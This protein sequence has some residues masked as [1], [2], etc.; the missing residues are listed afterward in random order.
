MP[1]NIRKELFALESPIQKMADRACA[2]KGCVRFDIGDPD[3]PTPPHIIEAAVKALRD[4]KTKYTSQLGIE[5]LREAIAHY[6]KTA[7]QLNHIT[8]DNVLVTV[9]GMGAMF[10]ACSALLK[11]GEKILFPEPSW[12]AGYTLVVSSGPGGFVTT[13]FFDDDNNFILD[14]S[15]FKNHNIKLLLVNSPE[16]PTGRVLNK[17]NLGKLVR[18]AEKYDLTIISDEVYEPMLYDGAKHISIATLAP[19]RTIKVNSVSK[20]YAMTGFRIGWLISPEAQLIKEFGKINRGIAAC[21]PTV[22]QYAALTAITGPQDCVKEMI[23]EYTRRQQTIKPEMDKIGWTYIAP[24][25]AFYTFPNIKQNANLLCPDLI[26]KAG[27]S[28]VPG[29]S[30]GAKHN[31]YIRLCFGSATVPQIK[32]GFR[33]LH[34]YFKNTELKQ[35]LAGRLKNTKNTNAFNHRRL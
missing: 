32:E 11:H 24:E 19:E 31:E 5:P 3:L 4:G 9:G 1:I 20:R 18:I 13:P 17:T 8:K 21:P 22:S 33:R 29:E 25:G 6:E 2:R 35:V 34:N 16:N 30:F 10:L 15:I 27:V 26:E 12:L 28:A 7:N 23:A 14:E